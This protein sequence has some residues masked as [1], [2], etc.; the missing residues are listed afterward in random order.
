[1]PFL[2]SAVAVE[3]FLD[4]FGRMKRQMNWITRTSGVL[5]IA[6]GIL[7]VTNYFTVLASALNAMTPDAIR[8]RL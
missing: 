3:R 5:M 8:N 6:V 4:F 2:L 1:M 7:M